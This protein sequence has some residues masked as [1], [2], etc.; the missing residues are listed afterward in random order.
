LDKTKHEI[1]KIWQCGGLLLGYSGNTAVR[2]EFPR[3]GGHVVV[4]SE[5]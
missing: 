2:V 5:S 4:R 1:E 3:F